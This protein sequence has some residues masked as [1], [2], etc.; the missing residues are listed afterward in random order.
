[1]SVMIKGMEMPES[2]GMCSFSRGYTCFA[3]EDDLSAE[4]IRSSKRPDAC[5]LV[6]IPTPHGRLI[7][8]DALIAA[9]DA[10]HEGEPGRARKL[11]E[12]A[13]TIIEADGEE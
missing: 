3:C 7:D 5:P 13:P 9:Y 8:G 6:E 12:D 1:M 2:C 10:Q 4:E 11:M